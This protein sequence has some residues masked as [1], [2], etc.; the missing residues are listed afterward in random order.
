MYSPYIDTQA[1][2]D[3]A[4]KMVKIQYKSLGKPILTIADALKAK[5]AYEYPGEGNV[6]VSGDAKGILTLSTKQQILPIC[7][8]ALSKQMA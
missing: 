5:S 1:N 4:A 7:T 2:A 8:C 6:V 3:R